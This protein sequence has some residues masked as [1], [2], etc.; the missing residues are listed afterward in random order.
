M[1]TLSIQ[2]ARNWLFLLA[3]FLSVAV[4]GFTAVK[5][6]LILL[7]TISVLIRYQW[8]RGLILCGVSIMLNLFYCNEISFFRGTDLSDLANQ[9][10]R[11]LT[12]F[13]I[14]IC[15]AEL[16]RISTFSQTSL[17]RLSVVIACTAA[18]LKSAILFVVLT[19]RMSLDAVQAALGFETVTD[20]IG[21]GLQRL[22]FPAD[23]ALLFLVAIYVG[24]RSRIVDILFLLATSVSLFLSFSRYLLAAYL[25]C[26]F[27]RYLRLRRLDVISGA[28]VVVVGITIAVFSVSLAT[29]FASNATDASDAA[30]TEQLKYLNSSIANHPLLGSGMG[31]HVNGFT[32]SSTLRFSYE[33]EWYAMAM[34]FG[35]IGLAWF[36]ANLGA[37]LWSPARRSAHP[38]IFAIIVSMWIASGFTNPMIVSVGS[39]FGVAILTLSFSAERRLASQE[40]PKA[41]SV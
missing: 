24:G 29:R 4:P 2:K 11:T 18:L 12:F 9:F 32:R 31:A 13:L 23:I 35:V 5:S 25:L 41:A 17:D 1:F 30:R 20:Q 33:M 7:L 15:G 26:L 21:F 40:M 14:L 16:S 6:L 8:R 28:S 39:A 3:A 37:L 36:L 34:Q 22:Q 10:F 27:L 38:A 19:G